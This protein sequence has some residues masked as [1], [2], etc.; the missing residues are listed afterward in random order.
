MLT[1]DSQVY[2]AWEATDKYVAPENHKQGACL[3]A[4]GGGAMFFYLGHG[5]W[6]YTEVFFFE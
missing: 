5:F 3:Q 6:F 4:E 2:G 1:M